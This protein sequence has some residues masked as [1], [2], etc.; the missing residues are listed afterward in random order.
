M[1]RHADFSVSTGI[2]VYF[3]DPHSPWQRGTTRT[4]TV[5]C[6]SIFRKARIC[7]C[8]LR[9]ILIWWLKNS[10]IAPVRHSGGRSRWRY[11]L[12]CWR[13]LCRYDHVNPPSYTPPIPAPS[14]SETVCPS[15][16]TC[17]LV[18]SQTTTLVARV[19]KPQMSRSLR[20]TLITSASPL[21]RTGPPARAATVLN[22]SRFQPLSALP[23]APDT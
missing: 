20:S 16:L 15:D 8:T 2:D 7:R 5:C 18:S 11:S 10:T 1:A 4:R 21:L 22:T 12:S 14:V 23:L 9:P 17:P 6:G 13:V 19:H 3:C